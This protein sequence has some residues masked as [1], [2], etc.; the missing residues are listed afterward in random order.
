MSAVR[1]L[2]FTISSVAAAVVGMRAMMVVA[3]ALMPVASGLVLCLAWLGGMIAHH[4]REKLPKACMRAIRVSQHVLR[5]ALVG[6]HAHAMGTMQS[7]DAQ[8]ARLNWVFLQVCGAGVS[9]RCGQRAL[10][11]EQLA[12]SRPACSVAH[13]ATESV[14]AAAFC[15]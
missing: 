9:R 7:V 4:S 2:Q 8:Q 14:A 11:I 1:A 13:W 5:V 15:L 3:C 6:L 12:L 10:M